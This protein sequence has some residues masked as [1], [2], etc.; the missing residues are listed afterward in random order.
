[1]GG[2]E[3][4]MRRM[5]AGGTTYRDEQIENARMLVEQTFEDD[6]SYLVDGV[7]IWNTDRIIHPRIYEDKY[8][9]SSPAQAKIQTR[10]EEPFYMGDVIPWTKHGYWLC[11][12]SNYLHGIQWEGTLSFC[13]H[14]V[15]FLSPLTGEVVEY[16]ISVTNATQY[17]SGETEKQRIIIGTSQLLV[18]ITYDEH[19]VLLDSG[20]RFLLDRNKK[21]PTAFKVTQADTITYSDSG[22]HGYI[23]LTVVEDQFNPKTDNKQEMIADFTNDP[24]GS[25]KELDEKT[26]LW[27]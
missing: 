15:R 13:N 27:L 3:N 26:D 7:K 17:G 9:S 11:I 8:R 23:Q 1:M 14:T 2:Y 20:F 24:I 18:D 21:L 4:F 10:L 5:K 6:P 19:T 16:P 22:E 12:N 25:G